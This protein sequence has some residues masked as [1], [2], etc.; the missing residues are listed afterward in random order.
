MEQTVDESK[1]PKNIQKAIDKLSNK[2]S[3]F[4]IDFEKAMMLANISGA[5]AVGVTTANQSQQAQQNE[6]ELYYSC[7]VPGMKVFF[8]ALGVKPP[9]MKRIEKE[10]DA[11]QTNRSDF[12]RVLI[13]FQKEQML[14]F[15]LVIAQEEEGH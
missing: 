15:R 9:K 14:G 13:K 3:V 7:Y 2:D 11:S 1:L 10:L 4:E 6:K 12:K 8:Q 5:L